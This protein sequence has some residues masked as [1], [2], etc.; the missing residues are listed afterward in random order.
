M[1]NKLYIL[2]IPLIFFNIKGMGQDYSK[3]DIVGKYKIQVYMMKVIDIEST[4]ILKKN[5]KY[6]LNE[7][8]DNTQSLS[9]GTWIIK[10]D[11]LILTHTDSLDSTTLKVEQYPIYR[12]S[13]DN[14]QIGTYKKHKNKLQHCVKKH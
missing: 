1:K 2:I 3:K 5:N 9:S 13:T 8:F 12:D 6:T 4:M 7:R 11:T 14:I 10:N